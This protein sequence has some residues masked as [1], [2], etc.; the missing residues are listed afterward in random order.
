MTIMRKFA[1]GVAVVALMGLGG[2]IGNQTF[3]TDFDA[4]ISADVSRGWHVVSV[5]VTVPKSLTVSEELTYEPFA[6]IV[7]R[8]DK[9]TD[10]HAQVQKIMQDAVA[11]GASG[12]TGGV[13]VRLQ[14]TVT[15]FHAMTFEAEAIEMGNIGVH[16]VNFIIRVVDARTGAVLAGPTDIDAAFPAK[17]GGEMSVARAHGE[18]QKSQIEAHVAETIAAWLGIGPDNRGSFVRTGI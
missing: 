16:N 5:D 2:C 11:R 7:W 18:T 10:R 9:G 13:P 1:A 8:E 17:T 15:R 6:D 12:L 14:V 4:P 3:R